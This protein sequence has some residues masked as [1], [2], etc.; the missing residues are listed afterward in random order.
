[1]IL[2]YVRH[3][4]PTYQPDELIPLGKRQAEAAGRRLGG[5]GLSAVYS[6]SHVRAMQTAQ[7]TAELSRLPV[8]PLEFC[9][10]DKAWQEMVRAS[11]GKK[12]WLYSDPE[13]K[14]LFRDPAV[15]SLGMEWYK[16]PA[17]ANTPV[18]SGMER[19]GRETDE[20]LQTL[21]YRHDTTR[22]CYIA[23]QPND[24]R[25]ALFA[26]HGFGMA[27]LSHVLDIPYP[28]LS[29]HFTICHTGITAISFTGEGDA[30]IPRVMTFASEA[31]LYEDRL[32]VT[33]DHISHG[34]G[35]L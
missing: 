20:F 23:E 14:A 26:H 27:F 7:P 17:F 33:F 6:S 13:A 1:M 19:I 24:R 30:I 21:G 5:L 25:V 3:G 31:H 8:I 22:H 12:H 9:R 2:Y 16:H 29:L 18:Q 28:L 10:E 34:G 11:D 32:P 35:P 15:L 4:F